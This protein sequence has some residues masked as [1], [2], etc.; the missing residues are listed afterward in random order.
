LWE[1]SDADGAMKDFEAGLAILKSPT[2][3]YGRAAVYR[4]KALT[5]HDPSLVRL[6]RAD[7]EASLKIR[8]ADDYWRPDTTDALAELDA[9]EAA[10]RAK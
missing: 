9:V 10:A 8:R 7:L 3:L 1:K 4:F 6:A 5:K 2:A